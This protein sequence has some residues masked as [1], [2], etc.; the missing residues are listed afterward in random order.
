MRRTAQLHVEQRVQQALQELPSRELIQADPL[1]TASG[2]QPE[3]CLCME[4]FIE[5]E[6]VRQLPCD[7]FF[8]LACIDRWFAARTFQIRSCPLCKRD[9]LLGTSALQPAEGETAERFD[10]EQAIDVAGIELQPFPADAAS[11][12]SSGVGGG[13][14]GDN[15][16]WESRGGGGDVGESSSGGG[17]G[18]EADGGQGG[19]GGQGSVTGGEGGSSSGEGGSGEDCSGGDGSSGGAVG[20]SGGGVSI[21][22]GG[23]DDGEG[24]ATPHG[25]RDG[26]DGSSSARTLQL[27]WLI[28]CENA[29]ASPQGSPRADSAQ[30]QAAAA[31]RA[32][33]VYSEI[34]I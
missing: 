13:A 31:E 3:C 30:M 7:H 12:A 26:N 24:T 19:D 27:G 4:A 6:S 17:D 32:G 14:G 23:A 18:G 25:G 1:L 10:E 29:A 2:E 34:N 16:G 33:G 5:G 21:T 28:G 11:G 20:S 8:H 22:L 15:D 9:P